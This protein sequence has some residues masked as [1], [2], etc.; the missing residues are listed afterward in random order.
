MPQ[1][2][3]LGPRD[4]EHLI[5]RGGDIFIKVDPITG[6]NG[7]AMG[8]QQI[9]V[10][11]GIPVHRHF[12]MDEGR[13]SQERAFASRINDAQEP[14][15]AFSGRRMCPTPGDPHPAAHAGLKHTSKV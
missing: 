10:G 6:S 8:S 4:G 3:V 9:L 1:G 14:A 2:Y 12:E 11:A 15:D 13:W 7:L 5:L